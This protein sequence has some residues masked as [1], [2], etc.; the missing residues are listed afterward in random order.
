MP[1]EV[2]C[3]VCNFTI[4]YVSAEN[5]DQFD[6]Y[7][8]PKTCPNCGRKLDSIW[9]A[10]LKIF[11]VPC[12]KQNNVRRKNVSKFVLTLQRYMKLW[13]LGK[14]KC[15]LCGQKFSIGE[16]IIAYE[17]GRY[18]RHYHPKCYRKISKKDVVVTP[19]LWGRPFGRD[20]NAR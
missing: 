5:F 10:E 14:A 20:R 19:L 17:V 7:K 12:N 11:P 1:L 6:P 3:K 9:N 16:T 13:A 8:L 4:C 18:R 2:K 15:H